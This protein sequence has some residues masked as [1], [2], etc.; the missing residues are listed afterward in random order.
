MRRCLAALLFCLASAHARPWTDD[1]MYFV[2]TDRF[3]DGDPANNTPAGSDPLLHDPLQKNIGMYHGG[4]LR[5]LELA[6]ESGYF[7]ELGVTALWIT[8]PVKNVWR[9]GYDLGGWKTGYHGYWTQDFLD[10]DPHLTSAVSMKGETY[11]ENAEGRMRHYRDFVALAHAKGLKVVQDVVLNHAGPVFF[12]DVDGD[13]VFDDQTKEEWVQPFKR[14]GFH[15]GAAWAD[16]AKWNLKKTQPDGPRELLGKRIATKGVLAE[17]PSYGRK[18]FSSESLGK[19]D[20]EEVECDFFSLRDLWTKPGSAH[21]EQLVD[22]F[23]EIYAFYLLD[24]GIDGLRIDT[25]KHVHHEFWDAFTERLRKRLG[26]KAKDKLLFGEVYDGDPKKLGGYTWRSDWPKRKE[27]CLD[28]VLD[29]QFCFAARDYLRREGGE[30]GNA[31]NLERAMKALRG[32]DDGG[33]PFYNPNP[34]PDGKNAREKS[35][36]FIENHDGLNRFRVAGVTAERH[37]LAQVLVLTLPGIPCVYYGAEVALHDTRGKVGQDTESGRLT[38]FRREAAPLL[39]SLKEAPSFQAISRAA[40]LRRELPVL[41]DGSFVPLWVDS[42]QSG[43]DDGVFAFCREKGGERVM[44][45]FNAATDGRSPELPAGGFP[46]GT[47][48]SVTPVCGSSPTSQ[49]TVGAEG[50]VKV[51]IGANA[52]LLLQRILETAEAK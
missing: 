31:G 10:I 7:T 47:Q 46:A 42:P 28:S 12:Y 40:E 4:D 33:R 6:I 8:P 37:D 41:R 29:F 9:S 23:V 5:G 32:G 48:L 34:G 14:D 20:G 27:P 30:H 3:H 35:I 19:S 11:P 22:E 21:F 15:P 13:G 18:G 45:V 39:D 24:V 49:A 2:M 51:P 50:R 16:T 36:T 26:G 1:V 17:L 38:L 44:V 52:A 43:E 25:V